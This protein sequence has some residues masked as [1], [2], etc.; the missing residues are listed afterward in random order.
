ME[1]NYIEKQLEKA[2]QQNKKEHLST[3]GVP[4]T[5]SKALPG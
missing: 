2:K 4:Y 5:T 3:F 1:K